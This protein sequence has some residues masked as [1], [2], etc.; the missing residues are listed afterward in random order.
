MRGA[1]DVYKKPPLLTIFYSKFWVK[2][3]R[4]IDGDITLQKWQVLR[5]ICIV[6]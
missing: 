5:K 6:L 4:L 1:Q 2:E 3:Q